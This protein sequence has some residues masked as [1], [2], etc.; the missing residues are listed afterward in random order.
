MNVEGSFKDVSENQCAMGLS[1]SSMTGSADASTC[2]N[3]F[4]CTLAAIETSYSRLSSYLDVD[5]NDEQ[6]QGMDATNCPYQMPC[7]DTMLSPEL[8]VEAFD[9][10]ASQDYLESYIRAWHPTSV[11]LRLITVCALFSRG[12]VFGI[13]IHDQ[14]MPLGVVENT[15][16]SAL[17]FFF[18]L[19]FVFS[20]VAFVIATTRL[21]LLRS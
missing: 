5:A 11:V 1:C 18:I 20:V 2:V 8:L 14:M 17:Y 3:Q 6:L 21:L 7:V 4:N 10:S 15:D 19:W 9:G 12:A 16:Y 13:M